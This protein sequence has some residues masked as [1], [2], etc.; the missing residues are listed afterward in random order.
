MTHGPCTVSKETCS[1]SDLISNVKLCCNPD[2]YTLLMLLQAIQETQAKLEEVSHALEFT[3]SAEKVRDEHHTSITFC[4]L[5]AC[6][7]IPNSDIACFGQ[8]TTSL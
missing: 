2:E 7:S 6:C 3:K 5:D 1:L 8:L 4:V